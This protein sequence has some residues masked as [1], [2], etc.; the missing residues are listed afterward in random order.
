MLPTA[1]ACNGRSDARHRHSGHEQCR[2]SPQSRRHQTAGI[3]TKEALAN[4]HT[5]Y[6]IHRARL[7]RTSCA[8]PAG[9]PRRQQHNGTRTRPHTTPSPPLAS[10]RPPQL[11]ST[12]ST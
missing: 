3:A 6:P 12:S 10:S 7:V 2:A 11:V 4:P 1:L 8:P 5:P 9:R